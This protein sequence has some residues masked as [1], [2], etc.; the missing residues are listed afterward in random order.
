MGAQAP[1]LLVGAEARWFEPAGRERVDIRRRLSLRRILV[2]LLDAHEDHPG[3][4]LG[5]DTLFAAGWAGERAVPE[6]AINR[7]RVAIATLRKLGLRDLLVTEPD[8]YRL[9]RELRVLRSE[10]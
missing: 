8:G 1:A 5:P 4:C 9:A 10:S 7:V 3:R 2:A 6:A